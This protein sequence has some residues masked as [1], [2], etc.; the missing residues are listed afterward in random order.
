MLS[1]VS[2]PV[3]S[4]FC[5]C[6]GLD[7]GFTREG[8]QVLLAVDSNA[9][10]VRTYAHNHGAGIA[11]VADLSLLDGQGVLR[12]MEKQPLI[13]VPRGVIGGPPCQPFSLGNVTNN[14][15]NE[16]RRTLPAK[17]AMILKSLNEA[18]N[19]D[20]FVFENVQGITF[21]KH[22]RDFARF[23]TLF[24][25]AGFNLF[26]GLLDAHDFGVPQKRPRV[27]V[28]G[29]NKKKFDKWDYQFPRVIPTKRLTVGD[30]IGGLGEPV[31][32]RRG[33]DADDFPVHPNHWTMRPKS[34]RFQDGTL[35]VGQTKGRS[36]RVLQWNKP[37]WTV[38]YGNREIHVHPSGTRRLSIYE[39]MLL[40]GFPEDYELLGNLSEQ[41]HQVSD[42]VPPPLASALARSICQFLEGDKNARIPSTRQMELVLP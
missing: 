18:F 26:E 4:L 34:R 35:Q 3:L 40:Q 22:R 25:D 7:L 20:F 2:V 38:A 28:V 33:L 19:L 14:H 30:A 23:K 1:S 24:E 10:A 39:A 41:V 6:G 21:E 32:F 42:A 31:L 13:A 5:G 16:L 17:Y 27:F 8:F 36:F 29:W 37:S 9:T 12:L 11:Q 15:N